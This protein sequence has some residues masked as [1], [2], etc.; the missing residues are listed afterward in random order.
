MTPDPEHL[1]GSVH[2]EALE[3]PHA[4]A[5]RSR[6]QGIPN[7]DVAV[8]QLTGE[9]DVGVDK[10][11]H[12][13]VDE[14]AR[15][16]A[17]QVIVDVT[18]VTFCDA[19]GLG[20]LV[21]AADRL[22]QGGAQLSVRGADDK[23]FRLFQLTDLV[24]LLRVER[25]PSS[26]A[27]LRGL[28]RSWEAGHT[29][30][31]LT[32]A[33]QMVVTMTQAVIH[34]ADGASITLPTDGEFKTVAASNDTVLDMDHDQYETGEGPCLD[35]ARTGL[36]HLATSLDD[37]TRWP[38][39]VP[40]AKAR[41]ISSILSTPVMAGDTPLGA[42]NLYSRSRSPFAAHETEWADQFASEAATLL[43]TAQ[44]AAAPEGLDA[45]VRRALLSREVIAQAQGIMMERYS[46]SAPTASAALRR[47]SRRTSQPLRD[48]CER[49]V[50]H[51][52]QM[53]SREVDHRDGAPGA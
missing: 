15:L 38:S 26:E 46:M 18:G 10:P 53:R 4:A 19:H 31:L 30:T 33:L 20:L 36:R 2:L 41:G 35:A 8:L 17:S 37:E 16:G 22:Q 29:Q 24:G 28:N 14:L 23:L 44:A 49:L 7:A 5:G 40:R 45:Q 1:S 50:G 6:A 51:S 42:L 11:F 43:S 3:F 52:E 25:P 9:I 13:L 48:L 47:E 27:L 32:A 34:G 39:F 21:V 12:A